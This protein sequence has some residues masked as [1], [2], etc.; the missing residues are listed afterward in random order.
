MIAESI[1]RAELDAMPDGSIVRGPTGVV[2]AKED[3][4]SIYGWAITGHRGAVSSGAVIRLLGL[5]LVRAE[6]TA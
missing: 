6:V 1:A 5:P 4:T 3:G 2:A